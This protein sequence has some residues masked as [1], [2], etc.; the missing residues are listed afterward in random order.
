M[1]KFN[2]RIETI[3]IAELLKNWQQTQTP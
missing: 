1:T 2:S 3:R